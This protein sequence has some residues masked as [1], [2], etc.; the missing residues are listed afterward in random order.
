MKI[1]VVNGPNLNLLGKR[2]PKVY[3]AQT[4]DE[5]MAELK[6][7]FPEVEMTFYQ[8]NVEGELINVLQ[9]A[10]GNVDGIVLNAGGYT[11]TSVAIRDAVAGIEVPVVEVHMS[12]IAAR[13]EFRH[14]SLIAAVCVGSIAGFG[15]NSYKL[16]VEAV[17]TYLKE[18]C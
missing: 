11:H 4:L 10:D 2:E 17:R 14:N 18:V 5:L 1:L 12:N 7:E 16:G 8:S 3:G 9:S 15:K 6:A 13:E